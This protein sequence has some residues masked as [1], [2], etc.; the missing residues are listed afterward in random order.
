MDF[1]IKLMPPAVKNP[2]EIFAGN[3]VTNVNLPPYH[4][5]E[6]LEIPNMAISVVPLQVMDYVMQ[7]I[8]LVDQENVQNFA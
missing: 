1:A 7:I 5:V 2:V 4:P 3:P 8:L 6:T